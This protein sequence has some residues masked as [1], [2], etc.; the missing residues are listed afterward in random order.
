MGGK[1]IPEIRELSFYI[2]QTIRIGSTD[3]LVF[4]D[5][6]SNAYIIKWSPVV[7]EGLQCVS[8]RP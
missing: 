2:M 3:T 5:G 1:V 6:G 7:E 4:F 8:M